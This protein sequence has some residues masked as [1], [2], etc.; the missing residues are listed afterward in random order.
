MAINRKLDIH[1]FFFFILGLFWLN[2]NTITMGLVRIYSLLKIVHLEMD[3]H[4]FELIS[5]AS[6]Y[7][8]LAFLTCSYSK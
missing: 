3:F 6:Y 2:G 7:V 5:V 8:R 4:W 1:F